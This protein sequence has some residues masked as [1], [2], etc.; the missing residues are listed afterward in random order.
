MPAYEWNEDEAH[1]AWKEEGYDIGYD[2]AKEDNA[3]SLLENGADVEFTAKC[4][5]LPLARVQEIYDS[6]KK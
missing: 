5:K 4:I 6:L 1:E 2:K 3:R